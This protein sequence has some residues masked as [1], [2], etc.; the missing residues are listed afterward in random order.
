[1]IQSPLA[2]T[3]P[4]SETAGAYMGDVCG[5]E[6]EGGQPRRVEE[7]RADQRPFGPER[8]RVIRK[9]PR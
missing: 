1:M 4:M 9:A 6:G 8:P 7:V 3:W 5:N 2:L